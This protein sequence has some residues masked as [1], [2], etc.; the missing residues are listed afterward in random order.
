VTAVLSLEHMRSLTTQ[1]ALLCSILRGHVDAREP[2]VD[3]VTVDLYTEVLRGMERDL[4][5]LESHL[6][7]GVARPAETRVASPLEQKPDIVRG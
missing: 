1:Y 5:M 2:L 4:W 7:K 3:A 6:E